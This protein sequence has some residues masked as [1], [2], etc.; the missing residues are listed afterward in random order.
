MNGQSNTI[1]ERISSVNWRRAIHIFGVV[2]LVAFVLPFVAYAFPPIVG[3]SGSYIVVS[4]SMNDEPAPVIQA[5]DVV[6]VYDTPVD[7]IEEG[8]V[9]TYHSGGELV[10]THR[11][12]DVQREGGTTYFRTKGDLNEEA[13]P[14]PVPADR[15]IGTVEVV[16]PYIGHLLVFASTSL[17]V[18]L[19]IVVPMSLLLISELTSI[20]REYKKYRNADPT[21]SAERSDER[22]EFD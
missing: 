6:Y 10:K 9:I 5:G 3:A 17:G 19:L 4:D 1:M 22:N 11:V 14:E 2:L 20:A 13:D 18:V 12:V 16:V 7:R 15:V 21:A 8:D